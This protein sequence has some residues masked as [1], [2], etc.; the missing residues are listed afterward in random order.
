MEAAIKM[1]S[2][3]GTGSQHHLPSTREGSQQWKDQDGESLGGQD[4]SCLSWDSA[5][6]LYIPDERWDD[7]RWSTDKVLDNMETQMGKVCLFSALYIL[8][9]QSRRKS[10]PNAGMYFTPH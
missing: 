9:T 10:P 8:P 2:L 6:I 7:W 5:H 3:K 1:S 4:L